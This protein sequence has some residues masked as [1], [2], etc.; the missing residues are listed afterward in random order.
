MADGGTGE[1]IDLALSALWEKV[2]AEFGEFRSARASAEI[3]VLDPAVPIVELTLH[4]DDSEQSILAASM[5]L[6]LRDAS[7]GTGIGFRLRESSLIDI[8]TQSALRN[9]A[10]PSGAL[11]IDGLAASPLEPA[12]RGHG[13]RPLVMSIELSQRTLG[14]FELVAGAESAVVTDLGELRSVQ[15]EPIQFELARIAEDIDQ[16]GKVGFE[17]LRNALTAYGREGGSSDIDGDGQVD[18][19]DVVAVAGRFGDGAFEIRD[20]Q[21]EDSGVATHDAGGSGFQGGVGSGGPVANTGKE[22]AGTDAPM[23]APV[24]PGA[25]PPDRGPPSPPRITSISPP[26]SDWIAGP[27]G[28]SEILIGFDTDVIVPADA[29]TAFCD[30]GGLVTPSSVSYDSPTQ[31]L[32]IS[33]TP[34]VHNDRLTLVLD[35]CITDTLGVELDGEIATPV[36]PVLPSGDGIRGG[37]AVF[38]FNALRGDF[39]NDGAVSIAGDGPLLSAALGTSAG[40]P[41]FDPQFDLNEDAFV[42]VLDVAALR[43]LDSNALFTLDPQPPT[44]TQRS[45]GDSGTLFANELEGVSVIFSEPVRTGTVSGKSLYAILPDGSLQV[46]DA[47]ALSSVNTVAT[48][49]FAPP[50]PTDASYELRLSNSVN[51]V[52]GNLLQTGA[53]AEAWTV[54]LS[55]LETEAAEFKITGRVFDIATGL[56]LED[57]FI[58][59]NVH[60]KSE[61]EP[62]L[63]TIAMT[64]ADGRFEF[65]PALIVGTEEF[66]IQIRKPGYSERLERVVATGNVTIEIDDAKLNPIAPLTRV[67]AVDGGMLVADS[68]AIT[69]EIPPNALMADSDISMTKLFSHEAIRDDLPPLVGIEGTFV[70]IEGVFGEATQIPVTL[71]MPN[72]LQFPLGARIPFGKIDHNTLEW[73]DLRDAFGTT[74][75]PA[76]PDFGIG[77]VRDDGAGGTFIEVTFDHFCTVCSGYCLPIEPGEIGPELAQPWDG[78]P[79]D[80]QGPDFSCGNS[81]ISHREGVLWEFLQLPG[82]Q[83]FGQPWGISL[84][85][86][87]ASAYPSA[88][89]GARV[90]YSST[91]PIE[92]TS[93]TLSLPGQKLEAVFGASPSGQ[94]VV[95]H[96]IHNDPD[97]ET[98]IIRYNWKSSSLNKKDESDQLIRYTVTDRFGNPPISGPSAG[99]A[100]TNGV[101]LPARVNNRR[102][103]SLPL[104]DP[105]PWTPNDQPVAT[106]VN[107]MSSPFGAGWSVTSEIAIVGAFNSEDD[108]PRIEGPTNVL[109]QFGNSQVELFH[110]DT[111]ELD[112][113]AYVIPG[114]QTVVVC[115]A[116]PIGWAGPPSTSKRLVKGVNN[117]FLFDSQGNRSVFDFTLRGPRVT[118]T[119]DRFGY[120]TT[121]SYDLSGR[122]SR[123]TSPTGF[124]YEFEYTG[125]KL[126]RVTDSAGRET[127]FQVDG[128]GDLVSMTNAEGATRTFSY[129]AR[130]LMTGQRGPRGE[131]SEYTYHPFT[132]R[133]SQADSYDINDG[134]LL[135]S[136]QF[137]PGV[138]TGFM[139]VILPG[140]D[141]T[142]ET[143]NAPPESERISTFTDGNG[144]IWQTV[145]GPLGRLKESID[146]LGQTTE[147]ETDEL[148]RVTSVRRP[149]GS[150]TLFEYSETHQ[151]TAVTEDFNNAR[152]AVS[153]GAGDLPTSVRNPAGDLLTLNYFPNRALES[154]VDPGLNAMQ[155]V[156]GDARFPNLPTQILAG[157]GLT[158]GHEYD[159]HGN[160]VRFVDSLLREMVIERNTKGE[161]T[162]L[163]RASGARWELA[164]DDLGR[165]VSA[166]DPA[167]RATSISYSTSGCG[168]S[169]GSPTRVDRPG[170]THVELG[171]DGL[172]R[173]TS[174][175]DE[176]GRQTLYEYSPEGTITRVLRRDGTDL[177]YEYDPL[178]R[179]QGV[180]DGLGGAL[181]RGFVYDGDGNLTRAATPES[182]IDFEYDGIGRLLSENTKLLLPDDFPGVDRLFPTDSLPIEWEVDFS[183]DLA[184]RVTSRGTDDTTEWFYYDSRSLLR[185]IEYSDRNVSGLVMSMSHDSLGRRTRIMSP[186][187]LSQWFDFDTATQLNQIRVEVDLTQEVIEQIDYNQYDSDGRLLQATHSTAG[188]PTHQWTYTYTP[189]RQLDTA[190]L[191]LMPAGMHAVNQTAVFGQDNRL[192]SIDGLTVNHDDSG[193]VV[194]LDRPGGITREYEWGALGELVEIR[195]LDGP[196]TL[197]SVQFVYDP[198]GR[199]IV[200][201]T[202]GQ[203]WLRKFSSWTQIEQFNP[204]GLR[205]RLIQGNRVD[206]VLAS[207]DERGEAVFI[208]R[209]RRNDPFSVADSNGQALAVGPRGPFGQRIVLSPGTQQASAF[210]LSSLPLENASGLV[211]SRRRFLD[212]GSARFLS[213]DPID[214]WSFGIQHGFVQGDPVNYADPLGENRQ[215]VAMMTLLST[216]TS[217]A[218]YYGFTDNPTWE[219]AAWAAAG[220][221]VGGLTGG[222]AS[223]YLTGLPALGLTLGGGATANVISACGTDRGPTIEGALWGGAFALGGGALPRSAS[224]GRP[225]SLG[226]DSLLGVG[227]GLSASDPHEIVDRIN[228]AMDQK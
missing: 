179:I 57:A 221:V 64:G 180:R 73:S 102:S 137:D 50:L 84:G 97:A 171:Y 121:H 1:S 34:P 33:F 200:E 43:Q 199:R 154:I 189:A 168:C 101:V 99:V 190:T 88:T 62:P 191:D 148:G 71:R 24:I 35:Y 86:Y 176:G 111:L 110:V 146:P 105:D 19:G 218:A 162:G 126:S 207:I 220:G 164:Y 94:D 87:S 52:S 151:V 124:F 186:N 142:G 224:F 12:N 22:R 15:M 61:G 29:I 204:S 96:Y 227:L 6:V 40:E 83:E 70:S 38:R 74:P 120:Q 21:L 113:T 104:E 48:F 140:G 2:P 169:V 157:E 32:S 95:A 212:T 181:L 187:G 143:V 16:D 219:G 23:I 144:E 215:L 45:P 8:E 195:D 167:M 147:Y 182:A 158:T 25:D 59:A 175:M 170:G 30:E 14:S 18:F 78:W 161:M 223:V 178:R 123:V 75:P 163:V 156:Y 7:D 67:C 122:L 17:D 115:T 194:S 222:L 202:N 132:G 159:D 130:H 63:P 141:S 118:S 165:L 100:F 36:S 79:G 188:S 208:H 210:G 197:V 198:L 4:L 51:D 80:F 155:F 114:G 54:S 13:S 160:L 66:L 201:S 37:Q 134:P 192:Q 107:Q 117:L 139:F 209:D 174:R 166:I 213:E 106:I 109:V 193:R 135:R 26:P 68:G 9:I 185:E 58:M 206:D 56:P 55:E 127:L 172:R 133:V 27:Q 82:F 112:C 136:R 5:G 131:R 217:L 196:D 128:S 92:S 184:N 108:D 44:V 203:I 65:M 145:H 28:I 152:L 41:G 211:D 46:A 10:V 228:E 214:L 39:S 226:P 60:P 49:C 103:P 90:E 69:L 177:R 47:Y 72:E 119:T 91:R 150:A 77:I 42:N 205:E 81:I 11:R 216:T 225:A 173:L 85:Y 98:G 183:Y 31:T 89:F 116:E 93:M 129:D 3:R 76:D 149:L 53:G 153:Y 138:N 20:P 125:G